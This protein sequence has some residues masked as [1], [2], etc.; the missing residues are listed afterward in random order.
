MESTWERAVDLGVKAPPFDR[1][2]SSWRQ[3]I[4][5]AVLAGVGTVISAYLALFQWGLV[6]SAW[7]P[8]FGKGT[9]RVLTSNVAHRI[10]AIIR[11][12][13]AALGAWA[14]L[15][16]VVFTLV[17]STRRWQYRPWM[18]VLFGFDVIP[19]G[20][21]S[22]ALVL[23]QGAIVGAWCFL[24]LITAAISLT[25]VFFA[26]DEVWACLK[27]LHRVWKHTKDR[28]LLWD[29]FCGRPSALADSLAMSRE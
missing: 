5:I 6:D 8:L 14:Y 4:P 26:Y 29:V 16:E 24:C 22:A 1:N 11:M 21:V 20:L 3:R 12:P 2:P 13:D 27:Y 18:V 17:G 25:L 15:S 7:D 28:K 19:L 23:A 9:E 10:D